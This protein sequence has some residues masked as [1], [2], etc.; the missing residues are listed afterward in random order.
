MLEYKVLLGQNN[1]LP[2]GICSLIVEM[3]VGIGHYNPRQI[4]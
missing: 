4:L 2:R 1:G 3:D